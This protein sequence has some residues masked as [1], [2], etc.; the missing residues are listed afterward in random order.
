[1][2]A[3]LGKVICHALV[4][5]MIFKTCLSAWASEIEFNVSLPLTRCLHHVPHWMAVA[6]M[7]FFNSFKDFDKFQILAVRNRV[8][9]ERA[10]M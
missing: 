7:L 10:W 2:L 9:W 8:E 3:L 6:R 5:Y 1:M 4:S